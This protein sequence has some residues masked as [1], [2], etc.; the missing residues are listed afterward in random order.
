MSLALAACRGPSGDDPDGGGGDDVDGGGI[1][2]EADD[3]RTPATE[4]FVGPTGLEARLAGFIDSATDSLDVMMYLF[5]VDALADRVIA[6]RQRGVDVRVLLDPDHEG[7]PD[8]RGQLTGAGVPV[9]DAPARFEFAHAK[10]LLIDGD[11]AVILSANFNY[12]ALDVERNYGAVVE[13]ADDVADLAAVFDADWNGAADPDLDCTRLIV[14]PVNARSRVLALAT[15]AQETLDLSVIYL[16]DS[17]VRTAV[18]QAHDRGVAVRVI[19]ADPADF[20]DNFATAETLRNQ[21]VEVRFL[22]TLDLHAKLILADGVGLVGS[23]NLSSTSLSDNREVG[24]L[25]TEPGP[26]ATLENQ[27]DADWAAATP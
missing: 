16:S 3:P 17:S 7:N 13:D 10:Y 24:V 14:S 27:L 22:R 25:V 26:V 12:G 9:R 21:G 4:V 15:G 20:P 6:A 2:C 5:T 1:G 8:V 11:T 19:L 18:I 23:Q